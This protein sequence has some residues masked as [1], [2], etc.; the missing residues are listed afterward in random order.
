MKFSFFKRDNCG[1]LIL[2]SMSRADGYWRWCLSFQKPRGDERCDFL[3]LWKIDYPNM[4]QPRIGLDLLGKTTLHFQWQ[5][6]GLSHPDLH[7]TR[8]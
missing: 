4:M 1:D 7:P 5:R 2:V 3:R 6:V 8:L